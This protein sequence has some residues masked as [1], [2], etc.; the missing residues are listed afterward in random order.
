MPRHAIK[1]IFML[2]IF[3]FPLCIKCVCRFH[4]DKNS[5][6]CV[7][8]CFLCTKIMF[9]QSLWEFTIIKDASLIVSN[10]QT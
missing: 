8:V 1:W 3:I 6:S 7:R 2:L 9:V 10:V 4:K 5:S